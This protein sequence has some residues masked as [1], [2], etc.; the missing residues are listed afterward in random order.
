MAI[1]GHND[2]RNHLES[3]SLTGKVCIANLKDFVQARVT[4]VNQ[5]TDQLAVVLSQCAQC[6]QRLDTQ[7]HNVQ[8]NLKSL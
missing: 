2:G 7:L 6:A 4:T 8:L 5:T 3:V 1:V